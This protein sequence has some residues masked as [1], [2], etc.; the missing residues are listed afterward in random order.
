LAAAAGLVEKRGVLVYATCSIEPM[1]NDEVLAAFIKEHT[2]FVITPAQE[3]L[4][5]AARSLCDGQGFFKSTPEQG[6]DGFFA[7]RMQKNN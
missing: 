2:E 4:P 3:Y 6:L 5:E 1:E 7:V